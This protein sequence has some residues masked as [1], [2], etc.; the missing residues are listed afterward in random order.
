[1]GRPVSNIPTVKCPKCGQTA[2]RPTVYKR[3]SRGKIYTYWRYWHKKGVS[4]TSRVKV[5]PAR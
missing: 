3:E 4:C 1:M 2:H 5:E